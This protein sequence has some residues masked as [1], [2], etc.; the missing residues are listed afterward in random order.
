[1]TDQ[2]EAQAALDAVRTI[3]R[4]PNCGRLSDPPINQCATCY[5]PMI[6]LEA[7]LKALEG[8]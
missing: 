8:K 7:R 2:A 4:C 5:E 3:M 6:P 1:M